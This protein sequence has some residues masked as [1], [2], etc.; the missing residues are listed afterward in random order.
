MATHLDELFRAHGFSP[1]KAELWSTFIE[2]VLKIFRTAAEDLRKPGN[3]GKFIQ[4]EGALGVERVRKSKKI[5]ERYPNED[6]ITSELELLIKLLRNGLPSDHFFRRHDVNIDAQALVPSETRAGKYVRKADFSV[7]SYFGR[8]APEIWIEAKPIVQI[9]DIAGK[10][11]GED[12]IGCF[13]TQDSP[14]T[15]GPLGGMLAYT[16]SNTGKSCREEVRAAL[17][18]YKPPALQ[19]ADAAIPGETL[20]LPF[21]RHERSALALDPIAVLHMELI[22]SPE[23]QPL[24][25]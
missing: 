18:N 25:P 7:I 22:F 13:F 8:D 24:P 12:G 1:V 21:S 4:K 20:P 17:K 14:Y 15:T 16:I 2:Y 3:W 19:L 23:I 10:Y 9:S 5:I 6:A 11:L